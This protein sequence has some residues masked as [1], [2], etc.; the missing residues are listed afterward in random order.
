MRLGPYT[1]T[2]FAPDLPI[3]TLAPMAGVGNWVFRLICARLGARIV[4]VEATCAVLGNAGG[5]FEV[6]PPVEIRPNASAFFDY[7]EK[8]SESGAA[9][10]CPPT[11]LRPGVADELAAQ[12]TRVHL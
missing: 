6:L 9:E 4:G 7:K 8:Y 11:G 12:Q 10:I 1:L 3:M 2:P 5:P